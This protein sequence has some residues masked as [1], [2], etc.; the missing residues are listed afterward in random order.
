VKTKLCSNCGEEKAVNQF[1]KVS[2]NGNPRSW[3]KKCEGVINKKYATRNL[4]KRREW[5]RA[6]YWKHPEKARSEAVKRYHNNSESLLE[7]K[8]L[9]RA[10][11]RL[12]VLSHYSNGKLECACCGEK[13]YWFLSLDHI[14]ND[15]AKHRKNYGGRKSFNADSFNRVLIKEGY[16]KGI[17]VLCMNCNWGKRQNNGVCP[18]VSQKG[19]TTIPKGSTAKRLEAHSTQP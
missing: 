5:C 9:R 1:F 6:N 14:N 13:T 8:R 12:S 16:P 2:S 7:K 10:A 3:C 19:S 18:H 11:D 4:E 15:G 17:Q